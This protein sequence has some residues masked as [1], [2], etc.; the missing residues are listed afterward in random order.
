MREAAVL[1][2]DL[3]SCCADDLHTRAVALAL[4]SAERDRTLALRLAKAH[5]QY[6]DGRRLYGANRTAEAI[7][8]FEAARNTFR[9]ADDVFAV[10]PWKYVASSYLYLGNNQ[11]ALQEITAAVEFCSNHQCNVAAM[12]QLRWIQALASGRSGDPQLALTDY[13]EALKGFEAGKEFQNAASIRALIADTLEFLGAGEDAWSY[14]RV[15]LKMAHDAGTLDRIYIAFGEAADAA[16]H[17]GH[18]VSA[19]LFRDVVIAAARR[20]ANTVLLADSLVWRARITHAEDAVGARRDLDEAN[21]LVSQVSDP[22]RRARLSANSAAARAQ[23]VP[24]DQAIEQLTTAIRFFEAIDDH[25]KP[26][27]WYLARAEAEEQAL[28]PQ[29]AEGDYL[30]CIAQIE[31]M[32]GSI[33]DSALRERF[34]SQGSDIFDRV[35]R[36]LWISG[37]R[38]EA[39]RL[40]E[41]SR[42]REFKGGSSAPPM[43]I[44]E[45]RAALRS[46]D[47]L[48][49]Y[50]ILSDRLVVWIIQPS[51][52]EAF[53]KPLPSAS[54]AKEVAE[55][56]ETFDR[57]GEALGQGDRVTDAMARIGRLVY[58]P[59]APAVRKAQRLIIVANKS[60]RA[61]PFS[62]LKDSN[63][64]RYLIEDHEIVVAPSAAAYVDAVR[65]DRA[66]RRPV[67][68][69]V[70]V[71]SYTEGDGARNLPRIQH[72]ND[73]SRAVRALY[74]RVETLDEREATPARVLESAVKATVVH[75]VAHGVQ[76]E[77]H[78]EFSSIVLAPSPGGRDLYA[79]AIAAASFRS[80]RYVFISTCGTAGQT[81]H[82][83]APLTL[84]ESFLSAG[85]PVVI[86]ALRPV[87]DAATAAFAVA[88]HRAFVE[89]GDAVSALRH[90]QLQA[91]ASPEWRDPRFWSPWI[92]IGGAD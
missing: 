76:N 87:D 3:H 58:D 39:F 92:A 35:I 56:Q 86:G 14:R 49:E 84:P 26:I 38:G 79:H 64:H 37:R 24:A 30:S 33:A 69:S 27:E 25:N 57:A 80:T 8:L 55:M 41:R 78:P 68:P 16:W 12:A 85:V 53:E 19:L 43:S 10:R 74:E 21:A 52:S 90:A 32:R 42:G 60:L 48:I 40:A 1:A 71:A 65:R 22:Q 61:V 34:F 18:L 47:I 73:E 31:A 72:G 62:A 46:S 82:N 23:L 13:N 4:R 28:M 7:P 63:T 6:L 89:T 45:I 70:L 17:R 15:A 36:H 50:A 67:R 20:E 51:G 81:S 83:D 29:L 44:E 59:M 66:M 11:R 91:I 2:D 9:S 75:I 77:E 5:E 88:V 54:L